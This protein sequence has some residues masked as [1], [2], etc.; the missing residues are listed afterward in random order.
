MKHTFTAKGEFSVHMAN[1]EYC[2]NTNKLHYSKVLTK[3]PAQNS[4]SFAKSCFG[5]KIS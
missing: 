5:L 4:Q 3:N 2:P 1:V